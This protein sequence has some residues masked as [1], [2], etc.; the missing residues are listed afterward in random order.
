MHTMLV[1]TTLMKSS[2]Q[3]DRRVED[4]G[5]KVSFNF[6]IISKASKKIL[7]DIFD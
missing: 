4:F 2:Y 5:F 3:D 6:I 1:M 7:E